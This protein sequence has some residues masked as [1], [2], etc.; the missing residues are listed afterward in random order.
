VHHF[1]TLSENA[2]GGREVNSHDISNEEVEENGNEMDNIPLMFVVFVPAWSKCAGWR[3][4][5]SSP[6]LTKHIRLSQKEDVHYYAEGTQHRRKRHHSSSHRTHDNENGKEG[7]RIASFDTSVFFLQNSWA[8]ARWP[9]IGEDEKLLKD[10]FAMTPTNSDNDNTTE[11]GKME[12]ISRGETT[13]RSIASPEVPRNRG[14][15]ASKSSE[16]LT[17]KKGS[18]K[19]KKSKVLDSAELKQEGG[20]AGA[21]KNSVKGGEFHGGKF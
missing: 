2:S 16:L 17:K 9:V 21:K 8:K 5:S 12:N 20:G 15:C 10:A 18:V 3:M 6:F 14:N 4:L 7:H 1:L 13:K 19:R 11:E